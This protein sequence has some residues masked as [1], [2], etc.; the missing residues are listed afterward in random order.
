MNGIRKF[1][2]EILTMQSINT[3]P[4]TYYEYRELVQSCAD[5]NTCTG[6]DKLPERIEA[7][8]LNIVRMNRLDKQVDLSPEVT[9]AIKKISKKIKWLVLIESWCGDGAQNIPVIVKMAALNPNIELQII[10]RDENPAIMDQ[11]LTNGTRSIPKLICYN[12]EGIE[13]DIWGPRPEKIKE[14][15]KEYKQ[16]NP[17][18]SHDEFVKNLHLWYAKDRGNSLQ[19]DF[20]PL[21]KKWSVI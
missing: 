14:M 16:N 20:L 17:G 18:V 21:L 10:L 11:Y 3:K 13:L 12:A 5:N 2:H 15:V 6:A 8:K 19:E 4:Y 9:D 7:T 1:V